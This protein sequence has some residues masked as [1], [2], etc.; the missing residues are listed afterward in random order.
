MCRKCR[1]V[2]RS[3]RRRLYPGKGVSNGE[4]GEKKVGKRTEDFSTMKR[5]EEERGVDMAKQSLL[6][7][8]TTRHATGPPSSSKEARAPARK[9]TS[10]FPNGTANCRAE[11]QTRCDWHH[12]LRQRHHRARRG[13]E[14]TDPWVMD[15]AD[16]AKNKI[17]GQTP[18][19]AASRSK[20]PEKGTPR[21]ANLCRPCSRNIH[22]T[23]GT[24]SWWLSRGH[25]EHAHKP[26]QE[27]A[28]RPPRVTEGKERGA[29]FRTAE[30]V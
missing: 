11:S 19:W 18:R 25:A 9:V 21:T 14:P 29:Q 2:C 7:D 8:R 10:H 12:K 4:G 16:H 6:R 15:Q 20:G 1:V 17:E 3:F 26:G 23:N 22:A 28:T 5:R 30:I 27:E 24:G 13:S